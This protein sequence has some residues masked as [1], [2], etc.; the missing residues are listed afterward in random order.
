MVTNTLEIKVTVKNSMTIDQL[1]NLHA[2]LED[3][4]HL[5]IASLI[6]TNLILEK[7]DKNGKTIIYTE[8]PQRLEAG[9][10]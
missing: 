1:H 8:T 4:V 9:L 2:K 10:R 7:E 6:M 5:F 3:E